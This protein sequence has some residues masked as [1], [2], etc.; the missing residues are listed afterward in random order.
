MSDNELYAFLAFFASATVT[1]GVV[2]K[3]W[4]KYL[5]LK[6]QGAA[7]ALPGG[8]EERLARIEHA[9]D[10][11]AIEVERI[12]EGQRF[13]TQLLA[14]R[15]P[16]GALTGPAGALAAPGARRAREPGA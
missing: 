3:S 6:R 8:V 4:I 1:I 14:E 2:A 15:A 10:A 7:G 12:S 16:G 5:A 11:I 9:V 13:T